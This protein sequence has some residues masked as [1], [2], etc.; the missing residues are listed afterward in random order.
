MIGLIEARMNGELQVSSH[1][2]PETIN[3]SS[4]SGSNQPFTGNA[5]S[6]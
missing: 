2:I 6:N 1:T 3:S 5:Y 4:S